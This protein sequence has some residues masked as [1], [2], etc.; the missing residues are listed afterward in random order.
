M[1]AQS[2]VHFYLNWAKERLDEMDA[3]LAV[4]D[5]QIAKMQADARGK[6]QQFAAEL[7]AKRNEFDSAL[8]KQAQAGEAAWESAKTRLEGEW[9]EFQHVLKQYTDTVGK[10]IEQ[11][12][13]VFQSQVEAQL[14]AWRDTADQL[15]AAAKAFATELKTRGR[16]GDCAD[17]GRCQRRRTEAREAYPGGNGILVGIE[18]GVD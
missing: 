1:P 2:S 6:A 12:Q 4:V 16:C 5:G 3:A 9:K 13:A 11:Q 8:K 17:E 15:N 14:K 10:H 7:R 18:C